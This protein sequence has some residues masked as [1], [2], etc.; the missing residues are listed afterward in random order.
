MEH[1]LH[2]LQERFIWPKM[3]EE[4]CEYIRS[5]GRCR[6][7]KQPQERAKLKPILATFPLELV[8]LDYWRQ[9]KNVLVVTDHFTKYAQTYMTAFQ[10]ASVVTKN[11]W[12]QL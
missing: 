6:R 11:L 2:L 8:H 12:D 3:N 5:F 10:S 4:V 9:C 1:T 7:F